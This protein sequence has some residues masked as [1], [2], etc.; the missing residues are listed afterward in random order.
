[1]DQQKTYI[2]H[3][4]PLFSG[5]DRIED[6]TR[7]EDFPSGKEGRSSVDCYKVR[8][9]ENQQ[10]LFVKLARTDEIEDKFYQTL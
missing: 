2:T 5:D 4:L 7:P 6:Y 1:L 3:I 8:K 9:L 10:L